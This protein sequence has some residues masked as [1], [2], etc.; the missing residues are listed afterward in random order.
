[1]QLPT[2][3]LIG[4]LLQAT[5]ESIFTRYEPITLFLLPFFCIISHY[6]LDFLTNFTYHPIKSNWKDAFWVTYHLII[7]SISLLVIYR[8]HQFYLGM[9]LAVL[10]D[11]EWV[12]KPLFKKFNVT[13]HRPRLTNKLS[14]LHVLV[15]PELILITFLYFFCV[16]A[17]F[18]R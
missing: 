17:L 16:W 13:L 18:V 5:L 6:I 12:L 10:P 14:E 3:L 1:M 11:I 7:Y 9:L 15:F 2:H 8:F 4:I